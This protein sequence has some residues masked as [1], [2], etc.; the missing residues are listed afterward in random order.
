MS[1]A[2]SQ[3]SVSGETRRVQANA[4]ADTSK[5]VSTRCGATRASRPCTQRAPASIPS[6]RAKKP[7]PDRVTAPMGIPLSSALAAGIGRAPAIGPPDPDPVALGP[8]E[9]AAHVAA[10]N[11]LQ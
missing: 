5:V 10:E 8:G 3:A 11:G 6:P 4:T 9:H 2:A 7:A 1:L